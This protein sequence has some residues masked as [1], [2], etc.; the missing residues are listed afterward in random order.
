VHLERD[1]NILFIFLSKPKNESKA[2][3][4]SVHQSF[5]HFAPSKVT[6]FVRSH[7]LDFLIT[8]LDHL[9]LP[10]FL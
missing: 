5:H 9:V 3:R 1:Y 10:F 4:C 7:I 8:V 2:I 6:C